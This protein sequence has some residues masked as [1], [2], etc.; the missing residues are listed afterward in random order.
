[1]LK[2][3]T[4]NVNS[5]RV[6]LPH[7]LQWLQDAEPTILA[8]QETKLED[9]AFPLECFIE[10]GYHVTYSGQS[11][12]N[13]VA[14]ISRSPQKNIAY[15]F[16][17]AQREQ[18]RFLAAT[19]NDV[20]II[21]VYVPNGESLSSSKY[22]YKLEWM[23]DFQKYLQREL[24]DYSKIIV[25]GDFNVAPADADVHNPIGWQGNV[26]VS[27]PERNAFYDLL[28]LGFHDTFRLFTAEAGIYSWW[29]YRAAA[30]RRNMGLRIDHILATQLMKEQCLNCMIDKLPRTWERPSDHTP[31]IATF[32]LSP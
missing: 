3:A 16:A 20:R 31:V 29:D 30:F 15:T 7:V 5:L 8:L 21:N 4:W 18:K 23:S 27:E 1:M 6:R 14:I 2:I 12:Y 10:R 24:I 26:L 9:K 13:G 22:Q 19:I 17:D 11:T 28:S 32:T 25:L